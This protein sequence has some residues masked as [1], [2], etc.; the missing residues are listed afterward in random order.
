MICRL[1]PIHQDL[2]G[3]HDRFDLGWDTEAQ[4]D[5]DGLLEH[6]GARRFLK[7]FQAGRIVRSQRRGGFNLDADDPAPPI[8][9][10]E[11]DFVLFA[12]PEM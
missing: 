8:L 11:L 7:F 10:Y 6:I 5:R 4:E 2:V 1:P 9:E 3:T 12:R